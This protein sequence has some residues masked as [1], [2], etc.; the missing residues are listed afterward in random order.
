VKITEPG[1]LIVALA[2]YASGIGWAMSRGSESLIS[3]VLMGCGSIA[4][5]V[6]LGFT[7]AEH[8]RATDVD[9]TATTEITI[10]RPGSGND[11]EPSI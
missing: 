7:L 3:G 6:W 5:G 10:G 9:A 2:L 8:Q 11:E 4:L 1:I